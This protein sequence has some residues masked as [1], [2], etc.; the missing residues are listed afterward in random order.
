[1]KSAV[2]IIDQVLEKL[3]VFIMGLMVVVVTWQVVTRYVLNDPS[4]Y[5]AELATYL[6]IW[7]SM[8]GAAYALRLR[9]HLGIDIV[10]VKLTG[11][12]KKFSE[13]FIYSMIILFSALFFVYGGSYLVYVT[14]TVKQLSAAFQL[15]VGYIYLVLPISGLLM[16]F[17]S[18]AALTGQLEEKSSMLSAPN[19]GGQA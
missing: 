11:S 9:A 18:I 10:T 6:L 8:L 3:L 12:A 5:T 7:V 14:L 4:S 13:I 2:A 15:P 16:I 19:P 17:Y 1:M